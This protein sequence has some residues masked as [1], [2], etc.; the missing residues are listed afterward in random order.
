MTRS[1]GEAWWYAPPKRTLPGAIRAAVGTPIPCCSGAASVVAC[2]ES[3]SLPPSADCGC[4]YHVT[5]E[6]TAHGDDAD[7]QRE[8]AVRAPVRLAG[9]R[10]HWRPLVDPSV[11]AVGVAT[12]AL[13]SLLIRHFTTIPVLIVPPVT[14]KTRLS[15]ACVP[16]THKLTRAD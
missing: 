7:R 1:R 15:V 9:S 2:A 4:A 6:D 16:L 3:L 13:S 5:Q 11:P 8:I 10:S 12:G 14:W